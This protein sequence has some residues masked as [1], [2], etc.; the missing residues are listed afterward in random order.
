[1]SSKILLINNNQTAYQQHTILLT[2]Q[3]SHSSQH[4]LP[5]DHCLHSHTFTAKS[6][7]FA[8]THFIYTITFIQS[9]LCNAVVNICQT[10][11]FTIYNTI[12]M[13]KYK[14]SPHNHTDMLNQI[15]LILQLQKPTISLHLF[16]LTQNHCKPQY[17]TKYYNQ[18]FKKY[19]PLVCI[20]LL[21]LKLFF[22]HSFSPLS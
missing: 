5:M 11:H 15:T 2:H 14:L 12:N 16:L 9:Y 10:A 7:H 17:P 13:S 4:Q 22:L 18:P 1:M 19:L 21:F 6:P 3:P 8:T 20:Y